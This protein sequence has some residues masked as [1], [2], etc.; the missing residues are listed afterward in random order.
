MEEITG[1][2][3]DELHPPVNR[4]KSLVELVKD[5]T[6]LGFQILRGKIRVSN[7]ARIKY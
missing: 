1:Y 6:F 2:T 3:E 5:A 7:N 4:A